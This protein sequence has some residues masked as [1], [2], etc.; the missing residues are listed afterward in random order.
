MLYAILKGTFLIGYCLCVGRCSVFPD[1]NVV[2]FDGNSVGLYKAAAYVVTQL[3]NETVTILIQEC[4]SSE[5]TVRYIFR[6]ILLFY[7]LSSC[8]CY[9]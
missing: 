3:M 1:L 2:T 8:Y 5:S 9:N 6:H 4:H 7:F